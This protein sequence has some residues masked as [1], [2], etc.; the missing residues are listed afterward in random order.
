[1]FYIFAIFKIIVKFKQTVSFTKIIL[2]LE[3][4]SQPSYNE[5]AQ[6]SIQYVQL[7][8]HKKEN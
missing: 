7:S 8:S 5:H 1:M 6:V 4:L 3:K 2:T